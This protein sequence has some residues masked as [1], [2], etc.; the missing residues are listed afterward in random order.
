MLESVVPVRAEYGTTL[1]VLE[2]LFTLLF[3]LEYIARLWTVDRPARYAFSFF[4]V[5]DLLA[6]VPTYLSL[7]LPGGQVLMV[8]RVLRVARAFRVLKLARYVGE[9]QVLV[10]ALKASRV[11]ITVFLVYVLSMAVVAG[12]VMYLIEGPE[13]GF[14]SIPRGV[15]WSI[16][17]L[18]TVG[19][20]DITPQSP[21]GQALAAALMVLGYGII[22]V[23]T[24]IVTAEIAGRP[25]KQNGGHRCH[26]CGHE[27]DSSTAAYCSVCGA[28]LAE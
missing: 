6:V 22:A 20:G 26:R 2:W 28:T 7:L 25:G 11:K 16:V 10:D 4:G 14:T 21:I 13:A 12:S 17:T 19:F 1:A 23:P 9:A 3:T 24:G 8:I 15:Y 5:I 18:T 27:A